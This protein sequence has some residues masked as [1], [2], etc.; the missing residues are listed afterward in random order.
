MNGYRVL[1]E[2]LGY[3]QV[4]WEGRKR[5]GR[6]DGYRVLLEILGYMQVL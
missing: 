1:L 3:M 5:G 2:I 4:L 6:G